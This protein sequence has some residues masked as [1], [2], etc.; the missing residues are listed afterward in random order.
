MRALA[1]DPSER[2]ATAEEFIQ[3]LP[4]LKGVPYV[5]P[6]L[7]PTAREPAA[8]EPTARE[9]TAPEPTVAE[10]AAL[11]SSEAPTLLEGQLETP[12]LLMAHPVQETPN[13]TR[14]WL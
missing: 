5:V 6:V 11:A 10:P 9:P 2:F 3:A 14:K 1:K 7:E 13:T 8:R 12:T 4:D